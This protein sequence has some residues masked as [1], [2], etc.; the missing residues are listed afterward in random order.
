MTATVTE[1]IVTEVEAEKEYTYQDEDVVLLAQLINKESSAS[2][3]GRLAVGCCV[4]NRCSKNNT[5]IKEE[6]FAPNQFTA[7]SYLDNY[8]ADDYSAASYVLYEG[9]PFPTVY[10]FNGCHEDGLNWFYDI[11]YQWVGAY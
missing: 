4:I 5:S 2:W 3:S 10:F 9:N 6:I 1:P 7:A 11:D 8:T